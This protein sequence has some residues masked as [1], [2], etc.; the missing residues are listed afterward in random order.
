M[1]CRLDHSTI[2]SFK[3]STPEWWNKYNKAKHELPFGIE[4]IRLSHILESLAGL[5]VLNDLDWNRKIVTDL[6]IDVPDY[7]RYSSTF[8]DIKNWRDEEY[9]REHNLPIN[10]N[11]TVRIKS[12]VFSR[13]TYYQPK[14]D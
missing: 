13:L 11:D 12:N 2:Q 14:S 9:E 1:N 3:N 4:S 5:Y 7:Y 6:G 10:N 8:L